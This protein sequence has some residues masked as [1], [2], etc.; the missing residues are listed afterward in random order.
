M[1]LKDVMRRDVRCVRLGD[2][3]DAAAR[4]MWE[5][6]CGCVPVVDGNGAVVGMLTDRDLCMA[7]WTQHKL[8]A[9]VPVTAAMAR[10]VRTVRPDDGLATALAAMATS[11]VRRLPVVDAR[12][13]CIGIVAANDLVRLAHSRPSALA[14]AAVV[15]TLAAIGAPRGGAAAEPAIAAS[16]VPPAASPAS[17][18]AIAAE[19]AVAAVTAAT[20]SSAQAAG[21]AG[22]DG[23]GRGGKPARRDAVAKRA[24]GSKSK[25]KG[26]K[27]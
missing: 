5:E 17:R 6:D 12:G 21:R 18:P 25:G 19:G 27:G 2:R 3:L 9:E 10:A 16:S 13:V 7:G 24:T 23:R 15:A 8:L 26:R 11:Q 4:A 14:P 22:T 20:R 1:I